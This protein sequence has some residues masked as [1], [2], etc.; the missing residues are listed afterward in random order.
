MRKLSILLLYWVIVSVLLFEGA[1]HLYFSYFD[2]EHTTPVDIISHLAIG[3]PFS[4]VT[5]KESCKN[6]NLFYPHPYLEYVYH[7]TPPCAGNVKGAY[8]PVNRQGLPSPYPI[9]LSKDPRFFTILLTGGSA[10]SN[11]GLYGVYGN[12]TGTPYIERYLNDHYVSPNGMPFRVIDGALG[13]GKYPRQFIELGLYADRI[14]AVITFDGFN[15]RAA[16]VKEAPDWFVVRDDISLEM[17]TNMYGQTVPL[18][19]YG[20]SGTLKRLAATMLIDDLEGSWLRHSY[21]AALAYNFLIRELEGSAA[22]ETDDSDLKQKMSKIFSY[23]DDHLTYEQRFALNLQSYRKYLLEMDAIAKEFGLKYIH[24]LQPVPAIDKPLTKEEKAVITDLSYGPAY[25]R[26]VDSLLALRNQGVP[27]FSL[28]HV[29]SGDT[30][31]RYGDDVHCRWENDC[32]AV[33]ARVMVKDMAEIW[34]LRPKQ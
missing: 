31:T 26:M 29:F 15:E 24:F 19:Y 25:K 32:N 18:Y 21:T 27:I 16:F 3:G 33:I 22:S 10:G 28:L 34:G 1:A 4:I 6:G 9:P 2:R 23:K 5:H 14:D 17:P 12:P 20:N 7:D 8:V 30:S 13:G 11:V